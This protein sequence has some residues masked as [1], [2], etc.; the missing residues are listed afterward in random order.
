MVLAKP[1]TFGAA[2]TKKSGIKT[3]PKIYPVNP[4]RDRVQ[5]VKCYASVLDLPQVP[6]VGMVIVGK[7]FVP[8]ILND[9]GKMGCPFAIITSGGYDSVNEQGGTEQEALLEIAKSHN[10]RLM[11]PNCLGIVSLHGP[12]VM[13]WCATLE[14][15]KGDLR[16][17]DVGL[18]SQSGALLGSIWDL[19]LGQGLGF[20]HLLSTG[21][22]VDLDLSDF[23]SYFAQD[24]KT[25]A[26]ISYIGG[27]IHAATALRAMPP[28]KGNRLGV[29]TCSGGAAG[30][31]SDRLENLPLAIAETTPEFDREITEIFGWGP[32]H[33]PV[34]IGK[35]PIKSF[36]IITDAMKRFAGKTISTSSLS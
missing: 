24:D 6:D 16:K 19:A 3:F 12:A 23:I 17:G 30:V 35:G 4:K 7:R 20:S 1:N 5:G 32:P 8:D 14:R 10:M 25:R 27:M 31:R 11:G 36:A 33:N 13:S 2:T 15:E 28:A 34:D 26:V 18:V 22:E 29:F 21:N 9:L